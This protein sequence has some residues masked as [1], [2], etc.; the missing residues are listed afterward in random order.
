MEMILF[1]ELCNKA[2]KFIED[3]AQ[4]S[5]GSSGILGYLGGPR[6]YYGVLGVPMGPNMS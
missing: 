2:S 6:E 5:M 3:I 1:Q 4:L